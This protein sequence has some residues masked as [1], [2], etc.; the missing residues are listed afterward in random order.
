MNYHKTFNEDVKLVL[1]LKTI[2]DEILDGFI[3]TEL[4]DLVLNTGFITGG[5]FN[6]LYHRE[7]VNDYDIYFKTEQ[8]AARFKKIIDKGLKEGEAF[9]NQKILKLQFK[10]SS[11]NAITFQTFKFGQSIQIQFII[12]Y[13]G[14]PKEVTNR[15]DFQH[16]KNYFDFKM[17]FLDVSYLNSHKELVFNMEASHPFEAIKRMNKFISKGWS[18]DDQ[19]I[20]KMVIAINQ[21]YIA[22]E[23]DLAKNLSGKYV[24]NNYVMAKL[25][26]EFTKLNHK[27]FKSKLE[28]VLDE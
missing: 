9:T 24:Q 6:S 19:E 8:A 21:V 1:F 7:Q 27:K 2:R 16:A 20:A 25:K 13:S 10:H 18:I 5:C 15:F 28:R 17:S 12:K 26:K 4:K 22:N 11:D 14:T 23:E 3:N